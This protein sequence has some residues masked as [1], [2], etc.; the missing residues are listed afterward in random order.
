MTRTGGL[1]I[2]DQSRANLEVCVRI[3]TP[4]PS[5]QDVVIERAAELER[6]GRINGF[7][8]RSWPRQVRL[9]PHGIESETV[10]AFERFEEW[11]S[12][13]GASLRPAYEVC[14]RDSEITGDRDEVLVVPEVSIAVYEGGNLVG[15]V[16]HSRDGAVYTV[17]DF[18]SELERADGG[19]PSG[20]EA[21]RV[22]APGA[23]GTDE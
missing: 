23:A 19:R 10:E 18:L 9:S 21:D 11:A 8:V 7:R 1:R 14:T 17:D 5:Q 15:V 13:N 6:E 2:H 4:I 16:P 12:R 22:K 20:R 3:D